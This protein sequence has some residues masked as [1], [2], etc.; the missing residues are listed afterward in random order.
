MYIRSVDFDSPARAAGVRSGDMLLEVNGVNVR[1][2][3]KLEVL[4][5]LE[6]ITDTLRLVV[7]SGSLLNESLPQTGGKMN[8][9]IA[10]VNKQV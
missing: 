8:N 1:Y 7:I 6:Q 5:S 10:K 2:F 9:L 3:T 4:E